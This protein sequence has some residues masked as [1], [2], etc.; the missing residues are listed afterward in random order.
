MKHGLG[1]AKMGSEASCWELSPNAITL[2]AKRE[3]VCACRELCRWQGMERDEEI[4]V[5]LTFLNR[6]GSR[7]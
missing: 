2:A 5:E 1:K 6:L 3:K 7:Q 4:A